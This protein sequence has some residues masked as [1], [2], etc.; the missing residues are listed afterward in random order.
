MSFVRERR[1]LAAILAAD[2]VGYSRLMREDETGTLAQLRTLRK[3]LFEPKIDEYGGRIVKTTGDGILIEFASAVDAVQHAVDVQQAMGQRNS[4]VPKDR[5]IELRLGINLG[6]VIVDGDDLYGDGVNIASRLEGLAEP[7]HTCISSSVYEQVRHKVDLAYED[8]GEQSVKNIADPIHV[9]AIASGG[10]EVAGGGMS[11]TNAL[12]RR[13]AVAVLPF[14]NLSSDPEQEYLANGL[15]EDIIT[16]LSLMNSFPVIA[17]N[18]TFAYKGT[19]PDIRKVGEELG[20]RYVIE[21]SF[22]RLGHRVRVTAQ[23]INADTGHHVWAERYDRDIDDI[24]ALQ[25]EISAQIAATVAPELEF[26]EQERVRAKNPSSLD[27]WELNQRGLAL[28]EEF[29][30]DSNT[31]ARDLFSKALALEATYARACAN[32]AFTHHVDLYL[33]FSEDR[34]RSLADLLST[35][36]KAVALDRS[37]AVAHMISSLAATWVKDFEFAILEGREAAKLAPSEGNIALGTALDCAGRSVEAVPCFEL[38]LRLNPRAPRRDIWLT[39]GARAQL[40]AG[41]FEVAIG[42]ADMALHGRPNMVEARLILASA[43]AQLG[44]QSEAAAALRKAR[45]SHSESKEL[46][47][48]IGWTRYKDPEACRFLMDGLRKAGWKG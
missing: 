11:T 35:A 18:S 37:D 43:L 4:G 10:G 24:F 13:P 25:D 38:G 41:N 12:F 28:F 40:N 17:R 47:L 14:E 15:T 20:A 16:A 26:A 8:R 31:A 36:R 7:G 42:S 45:E 2:V 1:R 21:G 23:L 5:R 46:T 33:E 30:K 48:P 44:R 29:T 27:A 6:D 39:M 34:D 22:R 19:S 32:L 3:E 9:Y